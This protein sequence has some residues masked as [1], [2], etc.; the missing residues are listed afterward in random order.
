MIGSLYAIEAEAQRRGLDV[1]QRGALRQQRS[2]PL[3]HQI[4]A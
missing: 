2:W 4:E 3:V 1:E